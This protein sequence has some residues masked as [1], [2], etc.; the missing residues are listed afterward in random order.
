MS[1]KVSARVVD[2]AGNPIG[3][4]F[5]VEHVALHRSDEPALAAEPIVTWMPQREFS[6]SVPLTRDGRRFFRRLLYRPVPAKA[7]HRRRY[8]R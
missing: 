6:F 2:M 7:A 5:D 3:S 8:G 1:G 4:V